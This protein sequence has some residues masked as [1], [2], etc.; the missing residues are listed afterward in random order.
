[1]IEGG[2]PASLAPEPPPAPANARREVETAVPLPRL[3]QYHDAI[4]AL[5]EGFEP[6]PKLLRQWERR[7]G[8][9]D[10]PD[11]KVDWA[12][13]E[14]LAFAAILSDG[15]PIR[16]TG[17]DAE[18]GTFSQRHLVLHDAATGRRHVPL[19]AL[20]TARA[21]FAVHNSPL[22]EAAAI[23]F[24]YGYSVHAPD[25]LVLWEAQFGDFANGGQVLIDQ[26]IASARAKW[27]QEPGL[28]LLLP[29]GYE[30]QGPEHSSARLERFLQLA[31][32]ENLRIANVTTAAQYFH[33]LRR[34]AALLALD[35]RPLV[36][37]TPKSLLRHP[38]AASPIDDL[39]SGT[40]RPVLDDPRAERPEVVGR[41]VLCSGKVAVDL[42]G[43]PLRK[44][45]ERVAVVRVEQLAPF[46]RSALRAV[47][48]R[49]PNL[50]EIVWVQ[51][52]PRNMGAWSYM[53]PRLRD[54]LAHLERPLPIRYVGRPER[55]SPAEGSAERH[56]AEQARIVAAAFAGADA[57]PAGGATNGRGEPAAAAAA[58]G[59]TDGAAANGA[60]R[61]S[62]RRTAGAAD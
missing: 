41:L 7:R 20:P 26:F 5:D 37:M 36:L 59:T 38:L 16:L 43:S 50:A 21:S 8:I 53:E 51:E 22:S 47:V 6:S 29:H 18:R 32:G 58:Q 40:F 9:L 62:A 27:R 39:A 13:A 4:H 24:E 61:P 33:L 35:R 30:G 46:Q 31:A 56:A 42:E 19:Q 2:A 14:T 52:E 54:L 49:Y 15:T 57:A 11:G 25:A 3:R 1:V 45:G 12:H 44:E 60:R 23:G 55:A 28:V 17:Q 48:E 34:Q 10:Q